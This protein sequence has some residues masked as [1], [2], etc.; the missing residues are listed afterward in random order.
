MNSLLQILCWELVS[1]RGGSWVLH[2]V[3]SAYAVTDV[4]DQ[5]RRMRSLISTCRVV[6]LTLA[7]VLTGPG[8]D[9]TTSSVAQW[10]LL[11]GNTQYIPFPLYL[12]FIT[13]VPSEV[14]DSC[15]DDIPT[16]QPY[17]LLVCFG[18]FSDLISSN[19]IAYGCVGQLLHL[20][21]YPQ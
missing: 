16:L 10:F 4:P 20:L 14:L 21:R 5:V 17:L 8:I 15:G 6:I 2:Y 13:H 3:K 11:R 9:L 19:P 7:T 12:S 1:K 18:T